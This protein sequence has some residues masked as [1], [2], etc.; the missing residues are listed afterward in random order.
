MLTHRSIRPMLLLA[1]M[2]QARHGPSQL[3]PPA[4]HVKSW[5]SSKQGPE[6][7]GR[8]GQPQGPGLRT[9]LLVTALFGAGLGGVWLAMRAEKEQQQQQRRT[10]ALRQASV[11][12]GDFS[13]LDHCGRARCKADFRGQWVLM[14]FGFTHCP[15]I[16]P[17][18]SPSS[19]LWT[20]SGT[21]LQPWPA[22]CGTSTHGC[23]A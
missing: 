14:Y 11:G 3:K 5:L 19:S 18:C 9:R 4:L 13:L 2:P 12:Q 6:E 8:Q 15:D 10:E 22:M 21:M 20:R 17:P 16:C 23:W 1:Q 7:T